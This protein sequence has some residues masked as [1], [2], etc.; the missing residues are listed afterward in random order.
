MNLVTKGCVLCLA[1]HIVCCRKK[2]VFHSICS[3]VLEM[4]STTV[5]TL[6]ENHTVHLF[7][8]RHTGSDHSLTKP[9]SS[10]SDAKLQHC[11]YAWG[12]YVAQMRILCGTL[13]SA[14][15]ATQIH[16]FMMKRMLEQLHWIHRSSALNKV[17]CSAAV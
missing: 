6:S 13:A 3:A 5:S 4:Y 9:N 15:G 8:Q 16:D 17:H 14:D 12:S 10:L 1:P 2:F 7:F 11:N